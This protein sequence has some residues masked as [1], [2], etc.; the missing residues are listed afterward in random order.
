MKQQ[1]K[2]IY[3]KI[4]L[5]QFASFEENFNASNQEIQFETETSFSFDKE[6][7]VLCCKLTTQTTQDDKPLLKAQL[8][9]YFEI[10]PQSIES[11]CT[12]KKITFAPE[13]LV[14]FASLSYG[15]LRGVIFTKTITSPLA[16]LVLPP[17][18]FS[19]LIDKPFIA[20]R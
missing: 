6:H 7:L 3:R 12:D 5:D 15:T 16:E 19:N 20:E 11:L 10:E 13:L 4:E 18:Y 9:N 2:Y 14:Q 8:L 1:V 17:V